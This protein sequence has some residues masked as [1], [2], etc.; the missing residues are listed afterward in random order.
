[1]TVLKTA[2]VVA[3]LACAG[4]LAACDTGD[5]PAAAASSAPD[6]NMPQPVTT[7][8]PPPGTTTEA[9][10]ILTCDGP[11]TR[12]MTEK[13]V[14]ALYGAANVSQGTFNGPE[15]MTAPATIVFGA[16]AR[17]KLTILWRDE[18]ARKGVASAFV[19]EPNSDWRGPGGLAIGA[20]LA[21]VETANGRPFNLYGFEWDY[22]GLVSDWKAG[23]LAPKVDKCAVTVRFNPGVDDTQAAGDSEFSSSDPKMK[24]DKPY[25]SEFGVGFGE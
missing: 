4:A 10:R 8:T 21:E 12:D 2:G 1:M 22:G 18:K 19:N 20:K 25:L 17:K 13:D 15:G 3:A 14:A 6:A 9:A 24:H 23:A 16:D 5:K 11:L 7:L